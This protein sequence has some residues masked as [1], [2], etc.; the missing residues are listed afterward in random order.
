MRRRVDVVMPDLGLG[1]AV[2]CVSLWLVD[3][4]ASVL[5][6]DRLV[7]VMS[8]GVTVDLPAPCGGRLVRTYFGEDDPVRPGDRL[9]V[10]EVEAE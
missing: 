10:I 1:D 3:V 9:G 4:G 6:D 7:E 8:D 2:V 5:A